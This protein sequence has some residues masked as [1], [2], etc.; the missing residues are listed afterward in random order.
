[1]RLIPAKL[2]HS[3]SVG[4]KAPQD[5]SIATQGAIAAQRFQ[6]GLR[7]VGLDAPLS[8]R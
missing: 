3:S 8:P 1:M 5:A 7:S 4:I 6:D 2:I